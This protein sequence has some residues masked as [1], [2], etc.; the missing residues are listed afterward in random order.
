VSGSSKNNPTHREIRHFNRRRKRMLT[1]EFS[2]AEIKLF[3]RFGFGYLL[4]TTLQ[5][6]PIYRTILEH[7]FIENMTGPHVEVLRRG[8]RALL[9][10]GR[11]FRMTP[12]F[13]ELVSFVED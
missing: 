9:F 8:S 12:E 5:A 10:T 13:D 11:P 7:A 1:V 4:A 6:V 3:N 2:E